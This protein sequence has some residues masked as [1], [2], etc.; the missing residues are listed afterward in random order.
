MFA[1]LHFSKIVNN[2]EAVI[3]DGTVIPKWKVSYPKF[4]KGKEVLTKV[5]PNVTHGR[6][7]F[8]LAFCPN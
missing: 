7:I 6:F 5:T 4:K 8:Y 2:E 3:A 1:A